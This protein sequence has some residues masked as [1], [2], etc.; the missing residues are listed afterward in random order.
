M[1]KTKEV[2]DMKTLIIIP[3][4]NE[5]DNIARVVDDLREN[6]PDYDY[7]VVNDG[8][9]DRTLE[10]CKE[11]GYNYLDMP[12]NVGLS[13]GVQAGMMYAYE[14]G[15]D[16]AI[17]FDGD[18]QHDPKFIA[19]MVEKIKEGYD[20]CIG[21]RFVTEKKPHSL[22]MLG[23][24]MIERIIRLTTRRKIKDP[25][26]GMRMFNKETIK[27]MAEAFDYG[28]EPDTMAHLIRCGAKICE[29]QV[30]M[31][32]R[33]A[34]ESYLNLR[35]SIKYMTHMFFSIIFIQWCRKKVKF[36]GNKK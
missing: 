10:I 30:E 3:A 16:C 9:R 17:Q 25:T 2:S 24:N 28:P 7:V 11:N 22:R 20:V 6:Y 36:G 13:A 21:S 27:F 5:Q 35:R 32:D 23:S 19:P 4:Y 26:S 33:T 8:S 34:G 18:G 14:K 1:Y 12:I 15:Y 31:H 29:I